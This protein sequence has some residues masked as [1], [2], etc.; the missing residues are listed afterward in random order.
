[1]RVEG[2]RV[3]LALL[4]VLGLVGL[5]AWGTAAGRQRSDLLFYACAVA[6]SGLALAAAR[7][8]LGAGTR[9][10]LTL[11]V[12]AAV[13]LRVAFLFTTPNLSGDIYRYIWDGRIVG[14]GFNPYL[15]VPADPALT[16]L[17]DPAQYGLIDK[18]DYAVTIYP[19]VAEA[20]FALVTR[21]SGS[22]LAMKGAMVL[23]EGVAVLAT[24]RLLD[25]L[26]RPPA[27]LAVYLLHPAPVWEIAGNGHVDAAVMAFLFGGFAWW[28]GAARPYAAALA[29][30]LGALVKPTAALGLPALWRPYDIKLPLFVVA[31]AAICYLPFL[32]AGMGVIGFLPDY[33]HEQGLDNGQGFFALSLARAAGLYRPWMTG[34]Y[35]MTAALAMLA[36][37][38]WTRRRGNAALAVGLGST[39]LLVIVF[40]MLLTPVFP[41]YFLVAAPFT[42][43]L[44]LWS[45]FALTTFGFLLYGFNADAPDLLVRWS[46]LMALV[47]AAAVRDLWR[48]RRLVPA[49]KGCAP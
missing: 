16:S 20:L 3:P 44:G 19:P 23:L 38:L 33:A 22:V 21:I 43:L 26:G 10:A 32:S 17:R 49:R 42:P 15:H 11:V 35:G 9:S 40:L 18:R 48:G 24:A 39:A 47:L 34:A 7:L 31:V 36:V 29:L 30:T 27:L 5:A 37:A 13:A 6:Q 41:W 1:M 8:A 45:P 25:R 28:G 2:R 14:S 4:A 46:L 12:L